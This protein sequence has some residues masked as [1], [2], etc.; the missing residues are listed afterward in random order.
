MSV[1]D[2]VRHA[3]TTV[4]NEAYVTLG[5]NYRLTDIQA[6]IGRE[7]L[8]RLPEIIARRRAL[9][10]RYRQLLSGIPSITLPAEPEWART[11]W[12][13]YCIRLGDGLEQHTVMQGLLA[14]GVSTR[15]G[16][17]CS[18]REPAYPAGTWE[19]SPDGLAASERAQDTGV[20]LP[21][22]HQMT[23]ADQ[24]AVAAALREVCAA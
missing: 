19:A 7:Q 23:T 21:L 3:A 13:S 2:T 12:Q 16:V 5:Y 1:P 4:I 14:R 18:H 24:D 8:Q 11:N 9:A 17:M 20:I 6:A 15:R 10:D 22:F